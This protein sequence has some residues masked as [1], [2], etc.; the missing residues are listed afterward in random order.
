MI[1]ENRRG[2]SYITN[3]VGVQVI[4]SYTLQCLN[5]FG[6]ILFA[7]AHFLLSNNWLILH[8]FHQD[9]KKYK[10]SV[11]IRAEVQISGEIL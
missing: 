7:I 2:A 11:W 5:K 8:I 6:N 1:E 3:C 9:N 10:N 4:S